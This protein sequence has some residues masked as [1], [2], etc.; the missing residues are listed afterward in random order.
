MRSIAVGTVL[1]TQN[2]LFFC[3]DV[4]R[5]LLCSLCSLW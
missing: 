4:S 5:N 1:L 2:F 3:Q